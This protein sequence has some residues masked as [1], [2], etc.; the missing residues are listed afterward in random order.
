VV[1]EFGEGGGGLLSPI[2]GNYSTGQ[3]AGARHKD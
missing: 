2:I 1:F 3:F